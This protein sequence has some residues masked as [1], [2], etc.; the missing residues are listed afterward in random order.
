MGIPRAE[1]GGSPAVNEVPA[2]S[3]ESTTATSSS[4][5]SDTENQENALEEVK[6]RDFVPKRLT[7]SFKDLT[8]RVTA[9]S[10]A[11]GETLWSRVDPSQLKSF[12]TRRTPQRVSS[13][14]T[15]FDFYY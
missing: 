8:V 6:S 11:L 7:L 4:S 13:S 15:S 3:Q 1:E 5:S 12:F 2:T 9:S 10:E 14:A